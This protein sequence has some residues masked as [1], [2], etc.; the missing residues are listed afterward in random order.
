[1]S[2]VLINDHL[3][4]AYLHLAQAHIATIDLCVHFEDEEEI[5][6][7]DTVDDV[8]I[9]IEKIIETLG[10]TMETMKYIPDVKEQQLDIF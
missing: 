7:M 6:D 9:S 4:R 2:K 8:G 10:E 3:L 5:Y 1:M